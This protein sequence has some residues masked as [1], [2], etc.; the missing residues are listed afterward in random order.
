MA[1]QPL[2]S[3]LCRNHFSRGSILGNIDETVDWAQCFAQMEDHGLAPVLYHQLK[4]TG[5]WEK[6]PTAVDVRWKSLYYAALGRDAMARRFLQD[7]GAK[8]AARRITYGL[9]KGAALGLGQYESGALRPRA[10]TDLL[11]LPAHW[12]AAQTAL[13]E[14]GYVSRPSPGSAFLLGQKMFVLHTAVGD[15]VVDLHSALSA[16]KAFT[17]RLPTE[18]ALRR[19]EPVEI[20]GTEIRVV[21]KSVALLMACLHPLLHHPGDRRLIWELDMALL[22]RQLTE[23]DRSRFVDLAKRTETERAV[24][25]SLERAAQ[26]WGMEMNPP[27]LAALGKGN[28]TGWLLEKRTWKQDLILDLKA[29]DFGGRVRLLL[30]ILFPPADFLLAAY[31]RQN[32]FWNRLLVPAFLL[33]RALK[34]MKR[35]WS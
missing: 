33:H 10:D 8:F 15:H 13:Q 19:T 34:G 20:D 21:E 14:L 2:I 26:S 18:L 35:R 1:L 5:E 6:L 7:L 11:C 30:E 28:E 22:S 12:T 31:G 17:R 32:H 29:L 27:L 25:L 3:T 9:F 16:R 4:Q 24:A 23:S